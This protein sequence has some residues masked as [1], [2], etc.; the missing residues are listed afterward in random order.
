[1]IQ[2][3]ENTTFFKGRAILYSR[4]NAATAINNTIL[5]C[6]GGP[7]TEERVY[8]SADRAAEDDNGRTADLSPAYLASLSL[9]GLPPASLRLRKGALIILLRNLYA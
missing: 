9:T 5:K 8:K 6:L 7:N 4:N 1:M 2:A 3:D